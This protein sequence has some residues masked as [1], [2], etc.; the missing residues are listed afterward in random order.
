MIRPSDDCKV[1]V[2]SMEEESWNAIIKQFSDANIYQTWAY[3]EIRSGRKN[4]SHLVLKRN[5]K[6]VAAVQVRLMGIPILK[7]GIAYA[8]WGPLWQ[9]KDEKPDGQIYIEML[10]AMRK[11]Y[12]RRR[13]Y[14]LRVNPMICKDDEKG[15]ISRM[16]EEGF[17]PLQD[18]R[19]RRTL[20]INL[21]STKEELRKGLAQKWRNSLNKAEKNNIELLEGTDDELFDLFLN[22]Y[23]DMLKRKM[24]VEPNDINE[25]RSIQK[26]LPEEMKMKIMLCRFEDALAAGSIFSAVGNTGLYLFGATNDAGMKSNGSYLMQWKYIEWLKNNNYTFYDLNGINPDKNPGTYKFKEGLSG[27]NGRDVTYVGQFQACDNS[28]SRLLVAVGEKARASYKSRK[29]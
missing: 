13:G 11:E 27:K 19:V 21:G 12:S 23:K 18:G 15:L 9:L 5:D 24:F 25:F 26:R 22:I 8:F 29:G 10:R 1:E 4:I 7:V 28:V 3:G 20:I 14:V 6:V 2:D 17:M 16:E